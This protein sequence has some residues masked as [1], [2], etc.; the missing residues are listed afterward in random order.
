M[1]ISYTTCTD[2]THIIQRFYHRWWRYAIK[3]YKT[4]ITRAGYITN[5][6]YRP[7]THLLLSLFMMERE[8]RSCTMSSILI[9]V[10]IFVGFVL[11]NGNFINSYYELEESL[12]RTRYF[13]ID[14]IFF[15]SQKFLFINARDY[16]KDLRKSRCFSIERVDGMLKALEE[17]GEFYEFY[18]F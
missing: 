6:T 5:K 4:Q 2:R 14:R 15:S 16:H 13:R 7:H 18:E 1:A 9:V 3:S 12:K 10:T 11:R 17:V 8:E